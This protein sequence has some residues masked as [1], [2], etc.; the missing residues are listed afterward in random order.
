MVRVG[1]SFS[2]DISTERKDTEEN[3][4]ATKTA[5]MEELPKVEIKPSLAEEEFLLPDLKENVAQNDE[6][7]QEDAAVDTAVSTGTLPNSLPK[8][9]LG[10][11]QTA[12]NFVFFGCV[13]CI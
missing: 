7:N 4:I 13:P 5:S 11:R 1:R 6:K 8:A 12:A 9:N 10:P 2:R 3:P